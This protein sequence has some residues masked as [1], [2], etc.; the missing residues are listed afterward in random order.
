VCLQDAEL[1]RLNVD[2]L[3][4]IK[5]GY[6]ASRAWNTQGPY[7]RLYAYGGR[8][9]SILNADSGGYREEKPSFPSARPPLLCYNLSLR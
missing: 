2:P 7:N 6:N 4:G 1:G 3:F 8:S 5:G 9:W